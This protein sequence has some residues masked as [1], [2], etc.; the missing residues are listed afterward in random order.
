MP[1]INFVQATLPT[2]DA[3]A[4]DLTF[5][6]P[7]RARPGDVL[8]LVTATSTVISQIDPDGWASFA[9]LVDGGT[10][11]GPNFLVRLRVVAEDEPAEIVT[12]YHTAPV[13]AP[14][15]A[16]LLY[17]GLDV[18]QTVPA[19]SWFATFGATTHLLAPSAT[20]DVYSQMYLGLFWS[21]A[22]GATFTPLGGLVERVDHATGGVAGSF[23]V[24]ELLPAAVGA[25]GTKE[26][27]SSGAAT[28]V[29]ACLLL[30]STAL[31]AARD[32]ARLDPIVGRPGA[33]GLP[34]EGV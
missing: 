26:A 24:A 8:L 19:A 28:G 7:S 11:T 31:L 20:L 14:L 12:H 34:V 4:Q 17:R 30:S 25:T 5:A 13:V 2:W 29:A 6:T 10:F 9:F 33:L 16:C 15:G 32:A 3:G 23:C 21:A 22:V 18:E 27:T 1:P